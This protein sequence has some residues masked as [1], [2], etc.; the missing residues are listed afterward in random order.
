MD[1]KYIANFRLL[2]Y[3]NKAIDI[4]NFINCFL[5]STTGTHELI[6]KFNVGLNALVQ[7]GISERDFIVI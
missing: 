2:S 3:L 7:H 1:Q 6:F 4:I 5:N